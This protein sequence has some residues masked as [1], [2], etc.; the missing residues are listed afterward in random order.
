MKTDTLFYELF[1]LYPL[2]FFE[3]I[4]ESATLAD[5]Y[6]FQSVELKQTAFRI[7]G[8]F[9]PKDRQ[10]IAYFCEVQFQE[11]PQLYHRF[12]AEVFLFLRQFPHTHDW[13]GLLLYPSRRIR[14]GDSR[15]FQELFE[16]GRVR[17][18]GLDDWPGLEAGSLELGLVQLV[19][20]PEASAPDL[21]RGLIE[22]ASRDVGEAR[23]RQT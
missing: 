14:P 22:R 20:E 9:L 18:I 13:K 1:Q 11:D 10:G 16:W 15:F 21:A 17:E 6:S 2:I 7:D 12:L 19:V 8:V 23:L 3:L 4:G 5:D